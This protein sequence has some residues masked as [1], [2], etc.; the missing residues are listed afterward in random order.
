MSNSAYGSLGSLLEEFRSLFPPAL[1]DGSG[2]E[3]MEALTTRLPA[4]T[5]DSRFGFEFDLANAKP[6]AD[7]CALVPPG[8]VLAAF[9]ENCTEGA[10]S[11][12]AGPGFGGFL[13]QQRE[14]P[15]SF[16][17][18]TGAVVILEYDLAGSPPGQH[19][20]PGVFITNRNVLEGNSVP[21]HDE[22]VDLVAALKSAAGW[23]R[24]AVDQGQMKWVWA[25]VKGSGRVKHAAVMPGRSPQAIRLIVH[26][27]DHG[28]IAGM[29]ERL[30]WNGDPLLAASALADLAGLVR[31]QTGLSID[32]TA[33]GVSPRIGLEL[34]RPVERLRTDPAGWKALADRLVENE[35]CLPAKA[36][37]L[38]DWPGVEMVFGEN[39]LYKVVQTI[40]HIKLVIDQSKISTKGYGA[41]DLVWSA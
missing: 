34:F 11:G 32:V 5:A 22:P 6:T 37:G 23:D 21:I 17:A 27:L 24:D 1:I 12:L 13:A 2:W 7:F 31:P 26:T 35:W 33:Q 39:G 10:S 20:P 38:V 14:N 18:R 15:Q 29:L 19:G 36:N 16:L 3:K 4:Y 9:Y 25:A 28:D 30:Q 40:S 41:V 8:S